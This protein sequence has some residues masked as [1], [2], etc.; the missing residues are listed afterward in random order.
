MT[1]EEFE[2]VYYPKY[3]AVIKAIARKLAHKNDAL[4][5][6]LVSEGL[7][8]LWKLDPHKARDNPDAYIRQAVKFRMIDWV[9]K[10]RPNMYESLTPYLDRGDQVVQ[11]SDTQQARLVRVHEV[12]RRAVFED[13]DYARSYRLEDA[14]DAQGE[15]EE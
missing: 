6:D 9:R 15:A 12:H 14:Q 13:E 2:S 10:E 11:D 4:M 7:I 8:A 3:H 5:E 1:N